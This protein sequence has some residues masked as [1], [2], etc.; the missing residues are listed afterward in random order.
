MAISALH[1]VALVS[2]ISGIASAV[3]IVSDEM[4]RPQQMP[5][6]NWV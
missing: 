2:L 5:T 1:I 4:S 3:W 6:M